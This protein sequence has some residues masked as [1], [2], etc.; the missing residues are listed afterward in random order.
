IRHAMR[1]LT[2]ASMCGKRRRCQG[3]SARYHRELA[4]MTAP[5]KPGPLRRESSGS[6]SRCARLCSARLRTGFGFDGRTT[7]QSMSKDRQ[8]A[9]SLAELDLGEVVPLVQ[10]LP[11]TRMGHEWATKHSRKWRNW[12]TRWIQV[13]VG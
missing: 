13:P 8:P 11:A 10:A 1:M 4:R 3:T 6:A 5:V 9:D 12:Q 2:V 7:S